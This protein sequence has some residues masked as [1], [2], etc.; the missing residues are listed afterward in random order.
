MA[1]E[2]RDHGELGVTCADCGDPVDPGAGRAYVLCEQMALC[3]ACATKRGG[4]YDAGGD[5]WTTPPATDD[6]RRPWTPRE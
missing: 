5:R 6:L 3:F 2:E 4:S 1:D